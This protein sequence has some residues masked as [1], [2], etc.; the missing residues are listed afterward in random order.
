LVGGYGLSV[1]VV[2]IGE[3]GGKNVGDVTIAC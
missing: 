2:P 3:N 1:S